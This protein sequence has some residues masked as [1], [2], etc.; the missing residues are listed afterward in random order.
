MRFEDLADFIKCYNPANRHK[1]K[2]T[3]DEAEEH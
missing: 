3:W 1:R 2:P